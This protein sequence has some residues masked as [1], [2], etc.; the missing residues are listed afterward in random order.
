MRINF[1]KQ[2]I[3]ASKFFKFCENNGA[4]YFEDSCGI[5]IIPKKCGEYLAS[6][7]LDEDGSFQCG[8]INEECNNFDGYNGSFLNEELDW[9][10]KTLEIINKWKI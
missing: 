7:K 8:I 6:I 3:K 5:W 1:K 10:I 2:E 4:D 9:I